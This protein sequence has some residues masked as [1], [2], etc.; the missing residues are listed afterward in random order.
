MFPG[1]KNKQLL[2]QKLIKKTIN[3]KYI[4]QEDENYIGTNNDKEFDSVLNSKNKSLKQPSLLLSNHL[5]LSN[6]ST[7][8]EIKRD[9]DISSLEN[10]EFFLQKETKFSYDIHNHLNEISSFNNKSQKIFI[11]AYQVN[12][13]SLK[14]F[15]QYLLYLH[16]VTESNIKQ[17]LLYF[18]FFQ[19]NYSDSLQFQCNDFFNNLTNNKFEFEIKGATSIDDDAY[20]FIEIKKDKFEDNS[21][22]EFKIGE[23]KTMLCLMD[24]IIN[25]RS[26]FD[27]PIHNSVF[28]LF[29]ENQF[30]LYL[31]NSNKQPFEAPSVVYSG[32]EYNYSN[33]ISVFGV[34]K[35][36]SESTPLGNYYYYYDYNTAQ[37]KATMLSSDISS[38]IS[39]EELNKLTIPNTRTYKRGGI[40]RLA[41]FTGKMKVILNDDINKFLFSE[42]K[43]LWTK[44]YNSGYIGKITLQNGD[45]Y[46]DSPTLVIENNDQQ[47]PLNF[48]QIDNQ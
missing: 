18:P 12:V 5:S 19:R 31:Y 27:F 3:S 33:F 11:C 42:K 21:E 28:S 15:L 17:Q 22:R 13:K 4:E 37:K 46:E 44:N 30:L 39:E 29:I 47:I 6:E 8:S 40:V 36:I 16:E 14:P 9:H 24:E 38:T 35:T 23:N 43:S 26:V 45:K 41:I 1:S 32:S 20:V 25:L 10:S 2:S 7:R 48:I 34:N